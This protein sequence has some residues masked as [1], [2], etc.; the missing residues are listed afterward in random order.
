LPDGNAVALVPDGVGVRNP[1]F[2]VT[3]AS[4]VTAIVTERGVVRPESGPSGDH[5]YVGPLARLAATALVALALVGCA[6]SSESSTDPGASSSGFAE[7]GT[8]PDGKSPVADC[9]SEDTKDIFL[10]GGDNSLH[11]F[12]PPTLE[13]KNLGRLACPTGGATPTSMAVDR[14]G[15]AWVRHSDGTIWKVAV[16]QELACEATA[17]VPPGESFQQ[18][19]MGFATQ[20]DGSKN[21]VLY[22]SDSGGA[23]L[24]KLDVQTME[25]KF[26]GPYDKGLEGQRSELTGTGGGKLYGFFTTFPA[27]VAEIS[28]GT[29][30]ILSTKELPGVTAGE[31]WAFSFYGGD[32]Y[33]YTS[34]QNNPQFP[35]AGGNSQI[36]RYRPSDDSVQVVKENAGFKIVGAG[37]STCAPTTAPR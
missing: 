1:S 22:L 18:F 21:E 31:A 13:I 17:F 10:I 19:G 3:P 8:L 14:Q 35:Q 30:S 2:D 25:L 32:F 5:D 15:I 12:H 16:N 6:K 29:G 34:I 28:K 37:V 27:Q 7:A 26:I 11:R 4:L 9:A 36:T 23:G 20:T 24:A 33:V